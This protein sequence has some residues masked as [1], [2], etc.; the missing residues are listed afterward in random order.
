[1]H[2]PGNTGD[3]GTVSFQTG[4]GKWLK[5]EN[6]NFLWVRLYNASE[7]FEKRSTFILRPNKWFA[8]SFA[9]DSTYNPG[10]Y[11]VHS[12]FKIMLLP[13]SADN[14]LERFKNKASYIMKGKKSI[15]GSCQ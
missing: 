2:S 15:Y 6:D 13:T 11:F 5:E 8:E 14:D 12:S 9:F 3:N 7:D 4:D 10:R 1:M